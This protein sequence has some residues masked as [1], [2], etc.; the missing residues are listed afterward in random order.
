MRLTDLQLNKNP[1]V[2]LDWSTNYLHASKSELPVQCFNSYIFIQLLFIIE[3]V[4]S[5][6]Y[7][8]FVLPESVFSG[9]TLS[10][11]GEGGPAR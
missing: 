10:I 9:R 2:A 7:I 5:V 11:K 8:N 3:Y 6:Y 4:L 1:S